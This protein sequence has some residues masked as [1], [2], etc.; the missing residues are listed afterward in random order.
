[1]PW[2]ETL[3]QTPRNS[4]QRLALPYKRTQ[5]SSFLAPHKLKPC[6]REHTQHTRYR[7]R[8]LGIQSQVK[9]YLSPVCR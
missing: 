7:R 2:S 4:Q 3:R 9:L 5:Y 8:K 1:M 6:A